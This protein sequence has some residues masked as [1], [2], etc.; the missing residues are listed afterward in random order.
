MTWGSI[1]KIKNKACITYTVESMA[2][3]IK[4]VGVAY[5]SMDKGLCTCFADE[6]IQPI[7]RA[8]HTDEIEVLPVPGEYNAS[9][10]NGSL[11]PALY[12]I[13]Y[14]SFDR[15]IVLSC[16]A[17]TRQNI[18]VNGRLLAICDAN[19]PVQFA[20]HVGENII[21]FTGGN[22]KIPGLRIN[23]FEREKHT[24]GSVVF[25]T[26]HKHGRHIFIHENR[27]S[28]NQ[29][30]L[31]E[32]YITPGI[33][34]ILD[35][36]L[37]VRVEV[38]LR[39][40]EE[41]IMTF[42]VLFYQ[43]AQLDLTKIDYDATQFNWITVSFLYMRKDGYNWMEARAFYF[44][45]MRRYFEQQQQRLNYLCR[46]S[47]SLT[48]NAHCACQAFLEESSTIDPDS[49]LAIL[50]TNKVE[51]NLLRLL[52]ESEESY[53]SKPGVNYLYFCSKLD[54]R[55][56]CTP[57]RV[58]DEYE[59]GKAFPLFVIYSMMDYAEMCRGVGIS[60]AVVLDL[61]CRGMTLG[62]YVGEACVQ[63]IMGRILSILNIDQS[64]IYAI[65]Y[66]GAGTAALLHQQLSPGFY[67]GILVA[68]SNINTE[69]ACNL[70]NTPIWAIEPSDDSTEKWRTKIRALMKTRLPLYHEVQI[71][72]CTHDMLNCA[73]LQ[74]AV[75]ME[76]LKYQSIHTPANYTFRSFISRHLQSYSTSIDGIG[77]EANYCEI[78]L[79]HKDKYVL[80]TVKNATGFVYNV[81]V[82][83]I[84]QDLTICVN[85]KIHTL[86]KCA[87]KR[88]H[89]VKTGLDEY[90]IV[91]SS[92]TVIASQKYKGTGLLDVYLDPLHIWVTPL[93]TEKNKQIATRFA[94]PKTN[95]LNPN[96]YVKYPI[97]VP[98]NVEDLS[99]SSWVII[100]DCSITCNSLLATIRESLIVQ[101]DTNG[102]F[103]GDKYYHGAY[104]MLQIVNNPYNSAY[105]ILYIGCSSLNMLNEN[106]FTRRWTL[107]SYV[108]GIHPYL[109]HEVLLHRNHKYYSISEDHTIFHEITIT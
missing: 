69:L 73:Y 84:Q 68:A 22:G 8:L 40:T 4:S 72:A 56:I 57:F 87:E 54:G 85:G 82:E 5:I 12:F 109:S 103:L 23:D 80:I 93:I 99:S 92:N 86:P 52:S 70:V 50:W 81:P 20:V 46:Q 64:R 47:D 13:I 62:S 61:T 95:A 97:G 21:I 101:T 53:F 91:S 75:I 26:Y 9:L 36:T 90:S 14:S 2:Q 19:K 71:E 105:S 108:Y 77:A 25:G 44:Y 59:T 34:D 49:F 17:S 28:P 1:M 89:F 100:D 38:R 7:F 58:P 102:F 60:G 11:C 104:S 37:P 83:L 78:S 96:I 16:D 41:S 27:Y 18:W 55:I 29:R 43:K 31:Y 79:Q 65:G 66:C 42:E 88:I 32:F 15:D 33:E 10:Q 98:K 107:P 3:C 24:H 76:M 35:I 39:D 106:I 51:K 45:S 6:T 63:E 74:K 30:Y 67:A 48:E 94:F